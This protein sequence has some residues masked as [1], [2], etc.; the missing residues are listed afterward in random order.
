MNWLLLFVPVP[1]IGSFLH[2]PEVAIFFTACMG[3]IP[4]AG[5]MGTATEY[6]AKHLGEAAGG[7][8]NA[9]LGNACEFIIAF[10]ALRA[11]LFDVV[12]ASITGSIIGNILLVLGASMLAGGLKF[13]KQT[14][15]RT[16]AT[17]SATLLALAAISLTVPAVYHAFHAPRAHGNE[18][19]LGLAIAVI[20]FITYLLSLLF[21]FK[22]HPF[23]YVR[24]H[25]TEIDSVLGVEGWSVKKSVLVLAVV[26]VM[27]AVLSEYLVH[28]IETVGH[29]L[30]MSDIFIGVVVVGIVGNAAEHSTAILM[31]M[32]NKMGL[33]INIA[34][35]SGAQIAL[36]VAPVLV[37]L[38]FA[39]GKPMDLHFTEIEV[40]SILA[41]VI[42]LGFVA[43]DGE[44][45]WMEGVQLLA[46]YAILG[47]AFYFA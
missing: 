30:G 36:L 12:K 19:H 40:I 20:L 37:F 31:A 44:S 35:G 38:S 15:N 21:S 2:W 33:A 11:G 23:L 6:L 13:Q 46:V 28:T 27:V 3:L 26:T 18:P 10:A 29:V 25:D 7:L 1:I 39:I 9:T 45:N 43:T 47:C 17:T 22:T 32:K 42:I 16:A 5:L 24:Q 4:L 8:L 41:S 34:L 14:F